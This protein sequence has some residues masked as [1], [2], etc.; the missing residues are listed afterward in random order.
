MHAASSQTRH[1]TFLFHFPHLK[2]RG[3]TRSSVS[4]RYNKSEYSLVI[5]FLIFF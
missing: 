5:F 4:K 1:I 3:S 2:G